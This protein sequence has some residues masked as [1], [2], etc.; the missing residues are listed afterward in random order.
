MFQFESKLVLRLQSHYNFY[1][2]IGCSI[3]YFRFIPKKILPKLVNW[4]FSWMCGDY[5]SIHVVIL[6]QQKDTLICLKSKIYA[7]ICFYFREITF[8]TAKKL[9][10]WKH[11]YY[12]FMVLC[13]KLNLFT[14]GKASRTLAV[15]CLEHRH[16]D[17]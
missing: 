13:T 7:F 10:L 9:I 16:P 14:K 8:P 17:G 2:K 12:P 6:F 15:L 5:I 1:V 11:C 4:R 3:N